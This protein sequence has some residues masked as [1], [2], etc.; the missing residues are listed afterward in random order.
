M[1]GDD[2]S[3]QSGNTY[4]VMAKM[5]EKINLFLAS[6]PADFG[7]KYEIK[8][9]TMDQFFASVREDAKSSNITFEKERGDF[10]RYN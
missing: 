8:F 3:H 4:N 7:D 1:W 9:S 10:W 6:N 5:I 2:W